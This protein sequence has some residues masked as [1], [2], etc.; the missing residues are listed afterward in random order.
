MDERTIGGSRGKELLG[1]GALGLLV[2]DER[3]DEVITMTSPSLCS[4]ECI[5]I[6][7]LFYWVMYA[8]Y[9]RCWSLKDVGVLFEPTLPLRAEMGDDDL[10]PKDPLH[11]LCHLSITILTY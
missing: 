5:W 10:A 7:I 4:G 11:G 9:A 8:E 2:F 1:F 6:F 3:K